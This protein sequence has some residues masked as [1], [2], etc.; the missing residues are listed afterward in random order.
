MGIEVHRRHAEQAGA[1]SRNR[2]QMPEQG[3]GMALLAHGIESKARILQ[4]LRVDFQHF[5][6]HWR[7]HSRRLA[8][9]EQLPGPLALPHH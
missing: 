6:F 1:I 5:S 8:L 9:A 4:H 7:N 2:R 3:C